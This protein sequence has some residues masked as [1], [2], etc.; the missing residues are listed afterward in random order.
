MAN[1]FRTTEKNDLMQAMFR[2]PEA[3]C[4][5]L[6]VGQ[7]GHRSFVSLGDRLKTIYMHTAEKAVQGVVP[8]LK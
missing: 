2:P 7:S 5:W 3:A 4:I 6:A 1:P 8:V